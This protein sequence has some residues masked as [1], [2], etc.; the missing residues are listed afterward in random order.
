MSRLS[1]SIISQISSCSPSL[2]PFLS[3]RL[4]PSM[5]QLSLN[6]FEYFMFSFS[7]LIVLPYSQDNKFEQGDSLYPYIFENYLTYYL[8]TDGT[9][10]PSLPFQSPMHSGEIHSHEY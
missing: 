3:A 10:P 4:S 2:S 1:Q 9:T 6:A 8:P 5:T 7:V